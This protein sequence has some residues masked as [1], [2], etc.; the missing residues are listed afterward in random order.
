MTPKQ[1]TAFIEGLHLRYFRP[2]EILYLGASHS[3]NGLN[4]LPPGSK[5]KNIVKTAWVADLARA[6][7]GSSVRVVSGY[8]SPAYNKRIGGA[9]ASLHMQ[10]CALDLGTNRP[11]RV[12][13]I[14]KSFRDA[15]VFRGGLGLYST[16]VHIDTRGRNATW[17]N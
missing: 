5:M 8:R 9:S 2:D 12:F 4:T 1:K 6:K 16:F 3:S 7:L 11:R 10:F 17:G 15:G 13:N 14:L